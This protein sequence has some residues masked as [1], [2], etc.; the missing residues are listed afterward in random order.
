LNEAIKH[1]Q[2]IFYQ[3]IEPYPLSIDE[4]EKL[5]YPL[6]LNKDL[7][8]YFFQLHACEWNKE[9]L[10]HSL[11]SFEKI[12]AS[13][14]NFTTNKKFHLIYFDAF[15]PTAQPE[16]WIEN[17]FRK[18]YDALYSKGILVTYCSK[19]IV[20]RAMQAAGFSVEKL[21]GPKGKRE[22]VR[23]EAL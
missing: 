13:L 21:P 15:D 1:N 16:L 7:H 4:A 20:R 17:I 2:K 19:G 5:N 9:I 11:F 8:E 12:N 22:I 18:M 10:I 23:A 3:T 6:T 14:Q